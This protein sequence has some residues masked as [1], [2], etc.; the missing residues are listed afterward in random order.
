[1]LWELSFYFNLV[2]IMY[3]DFIQF[4]LDGSQ[5]DGKFYM[6]WF[7]KVC[8]YYNKL[9]VFDIVVDGKFVLVC[10]C[11]LNIQDIWFFGQILLWFFFFDLIDL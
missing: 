6:V 4:G 7:G 8:F 9:F 11:C 5:I 1:M 10:D 3:G 2:K